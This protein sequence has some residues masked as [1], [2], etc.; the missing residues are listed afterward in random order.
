MS[1]SLHTPIVALC[2]LFGKRLEAL[3][4]YLSK[5]AFIQRTIDVNVS[6]FP[7]LEAGFMVIGMVTGEGGVVVTASPP[8]FSML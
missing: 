3:P 6:E 1:V 7:T 8:N 2:E 5:R 4:N